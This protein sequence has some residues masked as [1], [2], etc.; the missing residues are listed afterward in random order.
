M[1]WVKRMREFFRTKD[2]KQVLTGEEYLASDK[3]QSD[4]ELLDYIRKTL[5]T[6]WHPSCT[7]KMGCRSDP[8]AAI[9]N[10]TSV[11]SGREDCGCYSEGYWEKIV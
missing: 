9:D 5:Q 10:K 7:S 1:A 2:M 11:C 3:V 6:L 8:T 4:A